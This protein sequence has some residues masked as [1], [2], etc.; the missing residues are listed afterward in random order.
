MK[1]DA[2]YRPRFEVGDEVVPIVKEWW[3][4]DL[5]FIITRVFWGKTEHRG[6]KGK[7]FALSDYWCYEWEYKNRDG[8]IKDHVG[9]YTFDLNNELVQDGLE[10]ILRK[11]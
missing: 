6:S 10:R 11:L 7:E 1:N 5:A 8:R 2:S 4:Q 3:R 9:C